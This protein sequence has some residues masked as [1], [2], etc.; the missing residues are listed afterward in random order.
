[1]DNIVKNKVLSEQK[2]SLK[3]Q[4]SSLWHQHCNTVLTVGYTGR[5]CSF[6]DFC[7]DDR[8]PDGRNVQAGLTDK[9][10]C[11]NHVGCFLSLFVYAIQF[12]LQGL[13]LFPTYFVVISV[14]MLD[15]STFLT[16]IIASEVSKL[17]PV[18]VD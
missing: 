1:M 17:T 10:I 6:E 3:R 8:N 12:N 16:P 14:F 4:I 13:N 9:M 5:S 11:Q 15:I 7:C 2:T 18:S